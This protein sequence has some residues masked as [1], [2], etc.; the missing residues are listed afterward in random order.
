MRAPC[1]RTAAEALFG[2]IQY[3]LRDRTTPFQTKSIFACYRAQW[4]SPSA[5]VACIRRKGVVTSC[6][7][8]Q[9]LQKTKKKVL[10]LFYC[11]SGDEEAEGGLLTRP[12]YLGEELEISY[13]DFDIDQRI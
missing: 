6:L 2:N 11:F 1:V 7:Q 13:D 10:F 3:A 8:V 5:V 12:P 9:L 4:C